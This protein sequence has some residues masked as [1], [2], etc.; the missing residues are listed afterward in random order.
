MA[1]G[2]VGLSACG[3]AL[4]PTARIGEGGVVPNILSVG[5]V[6]TLH[7]VNADSR[8]HQIYSSDCPEV[9]SSVIAPGTES[10]L[11]MGRGPKLC[12][13]R[14]R[15]STDAPAYSGTV[16]VKADYTGLDFYP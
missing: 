13:F 15:L 10:A 7:F 14:D 2:L 1:V 16:E 12:H 6:G 5:A 4:S 11:N 3:S 9:S 8:P